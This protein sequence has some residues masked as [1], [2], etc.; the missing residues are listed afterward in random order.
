MDDDIR[1]S[2]EKDQAL[3]LLDNAI[4]EAEDTLVLSASD[5]ESDTEDHVDN[6][7]HNNKDLLHPKRSGSA[8]S[9]KSSGSVASSGGKNR[10]GGALPSPAGGESSPNVSNTRSRPISTASSTHSL[11]LPTTP[12]SAGSNSTSP[13]LSPSMPRHSPDGS[14]NGGSPTPTKRDMSVITTDKKKSNVNNRAATP[15]KMSSSVTTLTTHDNATITTVGGGDSYNSESQYG[16]VEV[17]TKSVSP[18]KD[19]P[20]APPSSLD[21]DSN[22]TTASSSLSMKAH[23]DSGAPHV[24]VIVLGQDSFQVSL[25]GYYTLRI[26]FCL[27]IFTCHIKKCRIPTYIVFFT[28][29]ILILNFK[30][31]TI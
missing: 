27:N 11:Q 4:Q 2:P 25:Q 8:A 5:I 1:F 12:K 24:S 21:S 23:S 26:I 17:R 19:T 22:S 29:L 7:M 16:R 13:A 20:M 31:A 14:S 15:E 6:V 18:A 9:N 10:R 3:Q 28:S 30:E